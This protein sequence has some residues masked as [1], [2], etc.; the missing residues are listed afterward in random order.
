MVEI[1]EESTGKDGRRVLKV[2]KENLVQLMK[3]L[4]SHGFVH[5]SLITGIDRKDRLEVVYHL[6]NLE[7]NEYIAVKTETLDERVPSV[8]SVFTS[9]N[10]DEREQYDLMGIVFEGHPNLKR[11]FLPESWVGHPLRKN[12]D[13][14]KVQYINMDENGEDYATFDP[15][16]GW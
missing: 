3:E 5:L 1:L 6:Q 8:T 15:G 13:I 9:A 16:D 2:A 11:L 14:S 12:Y 10:W 4:K 7:K